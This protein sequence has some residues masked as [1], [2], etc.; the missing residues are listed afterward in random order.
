MK[1]DFRHLTRRRR[2]FPSIAAD[3][4]KGND[5]IRRHRKS[6]KDKKRQ[7][8]KNPQNRKKSKKKVRQTELSFFGDDKAFSYRLLRDKPF[9]FIV[10]RDKIKEFLQL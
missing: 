8:G 9:R 6:Q 2:S 10:V 7:N 3:D 1:S 5:S 4:K